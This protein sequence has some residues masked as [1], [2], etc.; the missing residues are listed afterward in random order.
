MIIPEFPDY[1]VYKDGSVYSKR[2]YMFLKPM[3][4]NG[5]AIVNLRNSQQRK[6]YRVHR[7]VAEAVI[8]NPHSKP[9]VHHINENRLDNR[10]ENLAWATTKENNNAGNHTWRVA[11]SQA[12]SIRVFKGDLEQVFWG[13]NEAA[14]ILG[15]HQG[16]LSSVL[17]GNLKTVNGFKAEYVNK[18]DA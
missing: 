14:R 6:M 5:Y 8:E 15:I 13:V 1:E 9:H 17:T 3:I 7:L 4:R 18:E 10:V 12:K 16:H 11:K 2:S